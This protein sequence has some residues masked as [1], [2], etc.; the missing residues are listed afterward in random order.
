[1]TNAKTITLTNSIMLILAFYTFTSLYQP[2]LLHFIDSD[3]VD[4]VYIP[5]GGDHLTDELFLVLFHYLI[6]ITFFLFNILAIF[7]NY[8]SKYYKGIIV[9]ALS[10]LIMLGIYSWSKSA[11]NDPIEVEE[12]R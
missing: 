5:K 11:Q 4:G 9:S 12:I 8:R 10:L 6:L 2:S 3:Y 1:M 7:K